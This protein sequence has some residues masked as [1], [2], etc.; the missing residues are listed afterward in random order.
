MIPQT[1]EQWEQF[2]TDYD[3]EHGQ[4]QTF[5]RDKLGL[6]K[7]AATELMNREDYGGASNFLDKAAALANE[8]KD[9]QALAEILTLQSQALYVLGNIQEAL[10]YQRQALYLFIEN[11]GMKSQEV[12][13]AYENLGLL[14]A[15]KNDFSVAINYLKQALKLYKS[16]D[17]KEE[18][19]AKTYD[20]LGIIYRQLGDTKQAEEYLLLSIRIKEKDKKNDPVGL[21]QVYNNLGITYLDMNKLSQAR[22]YIT[23]AIEILEQAGEGAQYKLATAYRNLALIFKEQDKNIEAIKYLSKSIDLLE[24]VFPYGQKEIQQSKELLK[25]WEKEL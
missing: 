24:K 5:L 7:F 22:Y 12:A 2:F 20:N 6:L 21:A 18:S 8:L 17:E 15:A 14:H 4:S 1:Y 19:L 10:T 16:L 3:K 13:Q 9:K 11:K 23:K 25:Q